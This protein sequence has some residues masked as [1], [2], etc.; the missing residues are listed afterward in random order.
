[1]GETEQ[2]RQGYAAALVELEAA[3]AE[4][5]DDPRLHSSLG[6]ALAG[7]GR[8][9][10]AVAEGRR[11]T[12]LLPRS[13]DGFYYLPFAIDLAQIYVMVGDHDRA[14]EQLRP[15]H[16]PVMDLGALAR[17]R[18]DLEPAARRPLRGAAPAPGGSLSGSPHCAGHLSV[19]S[20]V[21]VC[22]A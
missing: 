11:A 22:K 3:V 4:R 20:P 14:I 15:A 10:E 6:I 18:S 9:E 19:L 2:A 1:L 16:Q 17:D 21:S 5:P 7:L 8:R 12:E 13:K